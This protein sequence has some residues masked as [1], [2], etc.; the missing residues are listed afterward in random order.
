MSPLQLRGVF[1]ACRESLTLNASAEHFSRLSLATLAA[2]HLVLALC[3]ETRNPGH[4]KERGQ[5]QKQAALKPEP[6]GAA[7][8]CGL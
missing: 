3:P 4:E 1:V 2:Y 7:A 5:A 8:F 6:S